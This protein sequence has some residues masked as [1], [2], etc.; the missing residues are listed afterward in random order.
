VPPLVVRV[1]IADG[2]VAGPVPVPSVMQAPWV[3]TAGSAAGPVVAAQI[4]WTPTELAIRTRRLDAATGSTIWERTEPVA[5]DLFGD[6]TPPFQVIADV[7]VGADVVVSTGNASLNSQTVG[8]GALRVVAHDLASGSLRWQ[9]VYRDPD[10]GKLQVSSP[11]FDSHGDLLFAIGAAFVCDE[12]EYCARRTLLKLARNDGH[13]IW[14]SSERVLLESPYFGSG[15]VVLTGDDAVL[16][17]PFYS[18]F[19]TSTALR[20]VDG[21]TGTTRWTSNVF[22]PDDIA[23]VRVAADGGILVVADGDGWAKLDAATG[24]TQWTN[25]AFST[26]CEIVCLEDRAIV[27]ADGS[28]IVVGEGGYQSQVSKLAA[29]GSGTYTNWT[30][31]PDNDAVR[32]QALDVRGEGS[33]VVVNLFHRNRGGLGGLSVLA[34]LD[35]ATGALTSQQVLRGGTASL[36]E[37]VT[38]GVWV[39][40]FDDGRMLVNTVTIDSPSPSANGSA[41]IDTTITAHGDLALALGTNG[42]GFA[43]SGILGIGGHMTYTGDTPLAGVHMNLYMPWASGV[44]NA[45]CEVHAASNCTFDVR[46][47]HLLAVVD[48][49]PGAVVDLTA[50]VLALPDGNATPVLSGAVFG[51]V[52]LDEPDTLNNLARIDAAPDAIFANGFDGD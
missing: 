41:V 5:V 36:L 20:S 6:G 35:T 16:S 50:E 33:N 24:A 44:R 14:E 23:A 32:S 31:V 48:L 42:S 34:K 46:D 43:A 13:V 39:G 25:P 47:G 27:L 29:D 17:G 4:G 51:P 26:P 9:A 38:T 7:A 30:L 28:L 15:M 11:V 37:P 52:G 3:R 21:A 1:S 10:G 22:A 49:T 45:H 12:A 18:S 40:D 8:Y 19:Y 2:S